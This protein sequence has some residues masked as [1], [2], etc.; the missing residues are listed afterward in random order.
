MENTNLPKYLQSIFYQLFQHTKDL[1]C[2]LILLDEMLEVGDKKEIPFLEEL[3][4][5]EEPKI[6]S[7]A[8]EIKCAL[9]EKLGITADREKRRLPMNLCFI[10][11]EFN[12][13]PN[14]I[15]SELD[16]EVALDIMEMKK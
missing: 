4:T 14:K 11:D 10:Y 13:R 12:I 2:R 16:F 5:N 15:D 8:F 3:E 9:Q 6:S 1:E 7:K